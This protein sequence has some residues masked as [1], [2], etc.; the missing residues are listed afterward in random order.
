MGTCCGKKRAAGEHAQMDKVSDAVSESPI[1]DGDVASRQK[2]PSTV[3]EA[4]QRGRQPELM[5]GEHE[6][7]VRIST[8]RDTSLCALD[9]PSDVA[10]G[11]D[12]A[13]GSSAT[14][15]EDGSGAD[16]VSSSSL[17]SR[18]TEDAKE[19]PH[20]PPRV[21]APPR[22]PQSRVREKERLSSAASLANPATAPSHATERPHPDAV[23]QDDQDVTLE[24]AVAP[25]P[26]TP[27]PAAVAGGGDGVAAAIAESPIADAVGRG[28]NPPR[29]GRPPRPSWDEVASEAVVAAEEATDAA[30][31]VASEAAVAA[32]QALNE[33][34]AVAQKAYEDASASEAAIAAQQA[35]DEAAAAAQ[36]VFEGAFGAQGSRA[37]T[38][39]QKAHSDALAASPTPAP[40]AP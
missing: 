37:E 15:M 8:D 9:A 40:A 4:L 36:K 34:A 3:T 23:D 13:A 22:S 29:A 39:R 1:H 16:T 31:K 6:A 14:P 35:I 19:E 17:D 7:A 32:Q 33:A 11:R 5:A 18:P 27:P 10:V 26:S 28:D 20:G 30:S 38:P 25:L 21:D 2:P 12:L 24:V